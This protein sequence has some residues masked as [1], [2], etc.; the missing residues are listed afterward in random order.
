MPYGRT[1]QTVYRTLA[2]DRHEGL[3][4]DYPPAIVEVIE[5][6][7]GGLIL[8]RATAADVDALA[9]FN[10]VIHSE[11]GQPNRSIGIWTHDLLTR[12]H[13]TFAA[14]GFLVVEEAATGK[15]VSSLNLIPQTWSYGSV[16]FGVGRV[17]LVG[18]LPDYRRRGLVRRQMDEAHRWSAA[19]GHAAQI[20]TGIANFYRQFGYEPCL[21][22]YAA[23]AGF[24]Q[25][26]PSLAAGASEPFHVRAATVGDAE[27]LASLEALGRPRSLLSVPRDAA[28]WRY[29]IEGM[30]EGHAKRLHIC[31]VEAAAGAQRPA[32]ERVGYLVHERYRAPTVSVRAYEL[33][34]GLSWLAVIPSVLRY[35][36]TFGD[37]YVPERPQGTAGPEQPED[38]DRR[39]DRVR[40]QLGEDHPVYRAL[41][42]RLPHIQPVD[43]EYV[44]VP[45]LPAFLRGIAAVLD[46][47]LAA[48]VAVGHT[49]RLRL[50]FF[51]DGVLLRFQEGQLVDADPCP[52]DT[53][54]VDAG[55][56]G[57]HFPDRTF[58][59]LLFGLHSLDE[60]EHA[61]A[62]CHADREEARVLLDALFPKQPSLIWPVA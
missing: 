30:T 56:R 7:D 39:F 24:R 46:R 21:P 42:E 10:A 11:P 19:L 36:K 23:R 4:V 41:P 53:N 59:H 16:L 61:F 22:M 47:R 49:G 40:F 38:A 13:P 18:T 12:P 33:V 43:P 35:L 15:I 57:A 60:L 1:G 51:R 5:R 26:I 32:G 55:P 58:L 29:E 28:L 31:V 8:R 6:L 54:N 45:D 50:G 9:D 17:E 44:R 27:F 37:G 3:P 2:A 52:D 34:P 25:H 48:S 14:G 20:I 62:D